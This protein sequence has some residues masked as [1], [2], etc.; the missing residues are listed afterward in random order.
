MKNLYRCL[1]LLLLLCTSCAQ[2]ESKQKE[3]ELKQKELELKEREL[4]LKENQTSGNISP[5]TA[6]APVQGKNDVYFK[7][8][9]GTGFS[10]SLPS[11]LHIQSRYDDQSSTCDYRA[12]NEKG[13]ELLQLRSLL[14]SRF[15][16]ND[17]Q[18]LYRMA[19]AQSNMDISYQQ[20]KA[21]WFVLSGYDR[22]TGNVVYWRRSVGN[23]YISDLRID[24]PKQYEADIY[25]HIATISKSFTSY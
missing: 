13:I 25:P 16:S 10:V 12:T 19:L 14:S 21:N 1:P 4:N 18:E 23:R 17:V 9:S 3:L 2:N 15:E 11:T 5:T 20:Q 7:T 22:S 24:Y 6:P 8:F